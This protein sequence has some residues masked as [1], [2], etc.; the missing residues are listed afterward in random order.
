[1]GLLGMPAVAPIA[2]GV[3]VGTFRSMKMSDI[4]VGGH[5]LAQNHARVEVLAKHGR[6]KLETR[7]VST[8][9]RPWVYLTPTHRAQQI[10]MPWAEWEAGRADRE[11]N[12]RT[13]QAHARE[14]QKVRDRERAEARRLNPDRSLP[15]DY[16]PQ[17]VWDDKGVT[18]EEFAEHVRTKFHWGDFRALC[19]EVTFEQLAQRFFGGLPR[20]VVRDFASALGS[21]PKASEEAGEVATVGQV[22]GRAAEVLAANFPG[23]AT[24][25]QDHATW[26]TLTDQDAE[27]FRSVVGDNFN[28]GVEANPRDFWDPSVLSVDVY[29]TFGWLRVAQ[30]H[31]SGVKLHGPNC[32]FTTAQSAVGEF[33]TTPLR[34]TAL[35]SGE[36]FCTGCA[37]PVLAGQVEVAHF[38]AASDVWAARGDGLVENWQRAAVARLV[39]ATTTLALSVSLKRQSRERDARLFFAAA[40]E[41]WRPCEE[42]VELRKVACAEGPEAAGLS[43]ERFSVLNEEVGVR[44]ARAYGALGWGEVPD[45]NRAAM[46]RL[47]KKFPYAL[48][49][50]FG[51]GR[52][53]S[54]LIEAACERELLD[55]PAH[56]W[57]AFT[58]GV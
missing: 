51:V 33:K 57:P 7:I 30:A 25:T 47:L 6:G 39:G 40:P 10:V 28:F 31:T 42:E 52:N 9:E 44:L 54:W 3:Q 36:V 13:R 48:G 14:L 32:Q 1:M 18:N 15:A 17:F 41:S 19:T 4:E 22:F 12:L 49:V 29:R 43:P 24:R 50:M 16:E 53:R 38:L 11:A 55:S 35:L 23:W 56:Q 5:Y 27:F 26:R 21:Q 34:E 20:G 58:R 2:Q 46:R 8:E 45:D 37:G